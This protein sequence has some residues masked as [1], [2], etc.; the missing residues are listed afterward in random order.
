VRRTIP[1]AALV[2]CAAIAVAAACGAA[3]A[4]PGV[5]DS[6]PQ[7]AKEDILGP[8]GP[9]PYP[10]G[11]PSRKPIVMAAVGCVAAICAL[12]LIAIRTRRRAP[13]PGHA[14]APPDARQL[15]ISR[16][17][18]SAEFYAA[19]VAA[20]RQRLAAEEGS[21]VFARTLRELSDASIRD[22]VA[23]DDWS[24]FLARAETALYANVEVPAEERQRDLGLVTRLCDSPSP[25]TGGEAQ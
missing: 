15:S 1:P 20:V 24:G 13:S 16:D 3:F 2:V 5:K 12:T 4:A 22:A 25:D 9:M 6:Q 14:P 7:Q 19:L 23:A 10:E 8:L 18:A 21:A 11:P 17:A